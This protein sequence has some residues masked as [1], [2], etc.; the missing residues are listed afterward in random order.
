MRYEVFSIRGGAIPGPRENDIEA[1]R[2]TVSGAIREA[3]TRTARWGG[4]IVGSHELVCDYLHYQ[5]AESEPEIR[6][7]HFLFLVA[8]VELPGL[9]DPKTLPSPARTKRALLTDPR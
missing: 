3:Y 9:D 1:D 5:T 6:Q 7:A 2:V 8:E 4:Q